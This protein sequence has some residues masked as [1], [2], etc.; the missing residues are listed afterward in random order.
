ML[1]ETEPLG[2]CHGCP[3]S[4][5]TMKQTIE[6][7]ILAMAPDATAIEVEGASVGPTVTADGLVMISLPVLPG[8]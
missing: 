5:V 3:S 4:A 6:E 8:A 7:A 2:S 1:G